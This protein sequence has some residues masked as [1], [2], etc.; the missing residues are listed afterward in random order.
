MQVS[1]KAFK[2]WSDNPTAQSIK[3]D[4]GAMTKDAL[5]IQLEWITMH[6]HCN[7]VFSV[8]LKQENGMRHNLEL[9]RSARVLGLHSMYMGH[10][11]RLYCQ[12]IRDGP[13]E[14]LIDLVEELSYTD[15]DT[16]PIFDCLVLLGESLADLKGMYRD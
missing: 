2:H 15:T 14:E 4:A 9:V 16:D 11:T 6:T 13:S 3:F 8:S 5:N 7:R 10:F 12:Q 1:S